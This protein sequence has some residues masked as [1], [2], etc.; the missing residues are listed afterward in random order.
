MLKI[1]VTALVF[2][3]TSNQSSAGRLYPF[4]IRI[5]LVETSRAADHATRYEDS[6]EWCFFESGGRRYYST[7]VLLRWEH[8]PRVCERAAEAAKRNG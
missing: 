6:L 4:A 7:K 8:A 5:T 2:M 3:M 1:L